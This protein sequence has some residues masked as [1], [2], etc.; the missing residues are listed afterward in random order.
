MHFN[1][2]FLTGFMTSGKST[3]GPILANVLGWNFYDLDKVIE[4]E[5]KKAVVDIFKERGEEYFRRR[6]T[7][8]LERL[9][10]ENN[11]IV[12]LGGGT[13]A[14][15]V[16][17]DLLKNNGKLIYLKVAPEVLYQRLKHKIDRPLFR[18]LVLSENP[19]DDFIKRINKL[20]N[21]REKYYSQADIVID[22][23]SR[24]VGITVDQLAHQLNRM[25]HEKN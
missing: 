7:S 1:K 11:I 5:E 4:K 2:V 12:A 8:V 9:V 25:K 23:D 22:C 18:D 6:E 15:Q 24:R 16:N 14:N 13:I 17:L 21:E 3:L 19:K 20:L 10:T